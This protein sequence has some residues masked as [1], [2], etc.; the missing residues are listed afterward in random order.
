MNALMHFVV[1]FGRRRRD[2]LVALALSLVT[3]TAGVALLG[4]SGWFLTA[5][6]LTTAGAAF[7]LFAPSAG[8][9]A[10]SFV[11]ILARYGERLA[12][13]DAT[14]RLLSDIR[15]WLF[16]KLFPLVPLRRAALGRADLVSRLTADVDALDTAFLVAIGPIT[17]AILAGIAM[18]VGLWFILPGASL[19]YAASFLVATILVPLAL[20]LATHRAGREITT[21]AA[22]L[23]G[24]VIDGLDCHADLV[25]LGLGDR[26][27]A[28]TGEAAQK[29]AGARIALALRAGAAG[30]AVQLAAGIALVGTLVAGLDAFAAG[31]IDGP[32]LVAIVLAVIAS[33]EACAILVRSTSR[34]AAAAAAAERLQ[35][36]AAEPP[37]VPAPQRPSAV[38]EGGEL[39]FEAVTFGYD[40][41]RP[42]LHDVDFTLPTGAC[43][44]FVGP[45]GAGKSTIAQLASRQCDPQQGRVLLNGVDLRAVSEVERTRRIAVMT[46]DAP[47]FLDT[48]RNNLLIARPEASDA[49]LWQALRRARLDGLAAAMKHGLDTVVGEAGLTL[50]AGQAR[51]LCLARMLLSPADLLVLDEPTSGLD[52]PTE[53]E[54]LSELP[55]LLAGR[56]VLVITHA[57]LPETG[58]SHVFAVRAGRVAPLVRQEAGHG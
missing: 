4:L 37:A 22:G 44:A 40:P 49:E 16:A 46:Q 41:A 47:V 12:G 45:S 53:M 1:L 57:G 25:A 42:V 38:P 55:Q 30:A 51:R 17:T 28:G 32:I 11:R 33:F 15:Q 23:R 6:A 20:G 54:L 2:L 29:L 31:A 18:S 19:V 13:H 43:A 9:R 10:L 36:L 14:L 34:L 8:V 27:L 7:N 21:H 3:L 5:A 26:P 50:S 39:R 52:R 48:I 56:T 35:G 24:A 58:F